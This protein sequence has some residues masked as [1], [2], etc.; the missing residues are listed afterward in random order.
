[1][2]SASPLYEIITAEAGR[3]R[4]SKLSFNYSPFKSQNVA[5]EKLAV[6]FRVSFLRFVLVKKEHDE[7]KESL[8]ALSVAYSPSCTSCGLRVYCVTKDKSK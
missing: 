7:H 8:L 6:V 2:E 4:V 1:M 5:V 3:R